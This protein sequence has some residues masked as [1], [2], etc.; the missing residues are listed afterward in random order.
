MTSPR[1]RAVGLNGLG[2]ARPRPGLPG[3]GRNMDKWSDG[4]MGM[5]G[6]RNW[7]W[8]VRAVVSALGAIAE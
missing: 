3:G 7:S 5:N 1:H 4:A 6:P 8:L 2:S